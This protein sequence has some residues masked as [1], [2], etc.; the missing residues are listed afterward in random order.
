MLKVLQPP[1]PSDGSVEGGSGVHQWAW[2]GATATVVTLLAGSATV[3]AAV[4]NL[5]FRQ[6]AIGYDDLVTF[7][8]TYSFLRT[9]LMAMPVNPSGGSRVAVFALPP[10]HYFIL[11]ALM[12][13]THL[14]VEAADI[15]PVLGWVALSTLAVVLAGRSLQ[16]KLGALAG[17]YAGARP[18]GSPAVHSSRR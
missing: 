18:V 7:N 5:W 12:W 9:G 17:L 15:L 13:M 11:A 8:G 1:V 6:R 10:T 4:L 14:P 16:W 3:V 2:V